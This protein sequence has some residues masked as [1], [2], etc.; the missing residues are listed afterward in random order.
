MAFGDFSV[1]VHKI[2][3]PGTVLA[4]LQAKPLPPRPGSDDNPLSFTI[5]SL[6]SLIPI[7]YS[8]DFDICRGQDS[9]PRTP[10]V[11]VDCAEF[12][13]KSVEKVCERH[14]FEMMQHQIAKAQGSR[15]NLISDKVD[16]NAIKFKEKLDFGGSNGFRRD[17]KPKPQLTEEE[18]DKIQKVKSAE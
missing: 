2:C 15:L 1:Q 4:L 5:D 11:K 14:K 9:N 18:K 7:G 16:I 17:Q 10:S 3:Q 12:V 6:A 13:N 8:A